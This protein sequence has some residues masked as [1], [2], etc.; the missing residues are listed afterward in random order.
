MGWATFLVTF[1]QTHLVTHQQM[2][3]ERKQSLQ[4]FVNSWEDNYFRQ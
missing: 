1:S 3:L 4:A 2:D